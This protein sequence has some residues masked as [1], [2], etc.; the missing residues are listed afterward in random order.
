MPC[1]G[2]NE[3]EEG[4]GSLRTLWRYLFADSLKI[5]ELKNML[6]LQNCRGD[7]NMLDCSTFRVMLNPE[8]WSRAFSDSLGAPHEYSASH[9]RGSP[10][11]QW[12]DRNDSLP[13]QETDWRAF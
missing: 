1:L 3:D 7:R 4:K 10:V 5:Y 8:S 2:E 6:A 13:W 9:R 11:L 12:R